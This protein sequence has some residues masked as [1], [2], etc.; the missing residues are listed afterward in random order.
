MMS[1]FG[2]NQANVCRTHG[3]KQ[4]IRFD[5]IREGRVTNPGGEASLYPE[6]G[7]DNLDLLRRYL[8]NRGRR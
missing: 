2:Q 3:D 8:P 4:S 5:S 6:V 1:P 7:G